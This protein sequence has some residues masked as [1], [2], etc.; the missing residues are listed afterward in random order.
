MTWTVLAWEIS[1]PLL[2]VMSRWTRVAALLF[3]VAF[4][5][6]IGLTMELGFF[7]PYALCLYL[8]LAPW[9][10]WLG[11]H[12]PAGESASPRGHDPEGS[13]TR[14]RACDLLPDHP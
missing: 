14:A 11:R 12:K 9:E 13:Q 3:G 8:P 5:L 6:G 10:W 4:H 2:V 7:A 1:F